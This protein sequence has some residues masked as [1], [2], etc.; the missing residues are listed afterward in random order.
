MENLRQ[1]LVPGEFVVALQ[2]AGQLSIGRF[3]ANALQI[4][5]IV[6]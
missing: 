1:L 2:N 3:S 6:A 4:F 5:S